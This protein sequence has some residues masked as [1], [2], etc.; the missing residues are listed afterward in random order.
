MY[1]CVCDHFVASHLWHPYGQHG[2]IFE[3]IQ[4]VEVPL[5]YKFGVIRKNIHDIPTKTD[6]CSQI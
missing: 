5:A 1:V 4:G 2:F 6:V 3:W